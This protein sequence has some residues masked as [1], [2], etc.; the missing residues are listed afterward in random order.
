MTLTRFSSVYDAFAA[1]AKATPLRPLLNVLPGTA[2]VYGIDAGEITYGAALSDVD[3]RAQRFEDLGYMAGMRVAL[4]LENRPSYFL[5]WLALNKLG[6]SVVPI[7]PDLRKSE[8]SYLFSHAEPVLAITTP[9]RLADLTASAGTVPVVCE[10]TALPHPGPAGSVARS[11]EGN[12]REAAVLYTS[13]TTGNPKGCVLPNAY[14]QIAGDWYRGLGGIVSLRDEGERMITTLPVFHM[15]AM[16]ASFMGMLSVGGCLTV[17]DRFHPGTWW[18]DVRT[19]R[20]TC[21]HY[22]GVMPSILMKA[23]EGASDRDHCVRF[24]FGAGIDPKLHAPFEDRFGFPLCEG[25][26][27]TETGLAVHLTNNTDDRLVGASC[28]GKPTPDVAIK[29]LPEASDHEGELLVRRTG[30]APRL[31]FFSEYYKDPEATEKAWDGGWF[32]TGD[33]VRR[34][35]QGR[36]FFVDRKKNVIRRSGENIAAV[37]VESVLMKH[38][39]VLAAGVAA[40]PDALRGDEVFACLRVDEPSAELAYSIAEWALDQMAYYKV[41]GYIAFV[42][43]LPLTATQKIQRKLLKELALTRV[44]DPTTITLTHLKKRQVA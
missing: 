36:M 30:D 14:F 38:P 16:A 21:L 3:A 2:S 35:D 12:A 4:L 32:H 19:S 25:W 6:L 20:A 41:P 43:E 23:P 17:L 33:L 13:G 37:E 31:G 18:D 15:N 11:L 39:D 22:L 26:A 8:L 27:M 24:G 34:D 10:N 28:L 29:I 40:V 9:Q 44:D 5:T 1:Q 7:N 42:P